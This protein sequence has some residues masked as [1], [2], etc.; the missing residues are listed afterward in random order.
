LATFC[1]RFGE[2][3]L[4]LGLFDFSLEFGQFILGV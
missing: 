3:D 4:A 1:R 2:G